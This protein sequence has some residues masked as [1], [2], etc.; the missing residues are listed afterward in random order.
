MNANEP[1]F[2]QKLLVLRAQGGDREALDQLLRSLQGALFRY[3]RG[4]VGDPAL[5]E[6]VLQDVFLSIYKNLRHLREP[7]FFR[8]WAYRIASRQAL[9]VAVRERKRAGLSFEEAGVEPAMAEETPVYDPSWVE[10]LP[11][12]LAAISPAG[13]AVLSLHYLEEMSLRETA[14]ILGIPVGTAKSRLAYGL[15]SIRRLMKQKVQPHSKE[16]SDE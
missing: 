8:A 9:R 12:L 13:R 5:A 4:L 15:A 16:T 1:T 10:S 11:P 2:G 7:R 14:D 6:D 3:V